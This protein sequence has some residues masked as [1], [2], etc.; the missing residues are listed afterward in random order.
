MDLTELGSALG[1]F[2]QD[3]MGP[4]NDELSHAVARAGLRPGDPRELSPV[5]GKTQRIRQVLVYASD[6]NPPAGFAL[7]LQIVALLR[8]DGAFVSTLSTYA[9]DLHGTELN[10]AVHAYVRRMNLNPDDPQLLIG[11]GKELD[12]AAARLVLEE[13]T[14][15][16]PVGGHPGSFPV[17]LAGA[18]TVLGL[19]V[20]PRVELDP[21]PH[22][23]VQQCLY[24]LAVA[25]NRLRN[26]VGTGHGRPGEPKKTAPLTSAEAR[27]V[28]RAT[29]LI[30]GALVDN[31]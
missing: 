3:G 28:A 27:L 10:D 24:L 14:G 15:S 16:Y 2:F 18:F 21:D 31:L 19:A 5:V 23:E 20:P 6:H 29:A 17:T 30:A 4:S 1:D 9:G 13:R 22:R 7:A 12:E 8:A 26:D 25:V 11:S